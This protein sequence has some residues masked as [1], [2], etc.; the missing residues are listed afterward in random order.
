VTK[1]KKSNFTAGFSLSGFS[2]SVHFENILFALKG[3]LNSSE[4]NNCRPPRP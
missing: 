4:D 1:I 2:F 3:P